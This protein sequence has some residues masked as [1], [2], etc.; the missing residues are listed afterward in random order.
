MFE[1]DLLSIIIPVYNSDQYIDDCL[2]S[3]INQKYQK[4]EIICINDASFDKSSMIMDLIKKIYTDIRIKIIHLE[5]SLGPGNARNIGLKES[6]GEFICFIDSDDFVDYEYYYQQVDIMKQTGVD[7]TRTGNMIAFSETRKI[8][9]PV[10]DLTII[11]NILDCKSAIYPLFGTAPIDSVSACT[12]VYR[13]NILDKIKYSFPQNVW[14]YEDREPIINLYCNSNKF[15][16]LDCY[17]YFV[18]RQNQKKHSFRDIE[19]R[20]IDLFCVFKNVIKNVNIKGDQLFIKKV[21]IQYLN[22]IE[23]LLTDLHKENIE[24]EKIL[25]IVSQNLIKIDYSICHE[26]LKNRKGSQIKNILDKVEHQ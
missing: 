16:I 11:N 5:H 7:F 14:T 6:N 25:D 24:D 2:L 4:I 3:L 10:D 23:K 26:F 9:Y 8:V 12:G 1:K 17:G 22:C 15:I 20:V 19:R 13:R 18:R 21:N